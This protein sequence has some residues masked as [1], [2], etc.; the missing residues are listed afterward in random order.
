MGA[1]SAGTS[2]VFVTTMS[3]MHIAALLVALIAC[4]FDLRTRRIPNWLTFGSAAFA[5]G[6]RFVAGGWSGGALPK[7]GTSTAMH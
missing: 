1:V 7:P 3:D 6:F 2:R 4:A 5:L